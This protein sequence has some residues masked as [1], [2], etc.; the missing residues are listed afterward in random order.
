ME[1]CFR[2]LL[3]FRRDQIIKQ[4]GSLISEWAAFH[5]LPLFYKPT[6]SEGSVRLV[7]SRISK[8]AYFSTYVLL[9][10]LAYLGQKKL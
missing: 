8:G 3:P 1:I 5:G 6:L 2:N 10:H 4:E 7:T 9:L